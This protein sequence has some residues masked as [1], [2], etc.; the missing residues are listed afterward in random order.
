[1]HAAER[2]GCRDAQRPLSLRRTPRSIGLGFFNSG[3]DTKDAIIEA[4]SGF[5]ERNLSCRAL[6]K[7]RAESFLEPLDALG[8]HRRGEAEGAARRRHAAG[9]NHARE[10]F[11]IPKIRHQSGHSFRER[12]AAPRLSDAQSRCST[13]NCCVSPI[14]RSR[15]IQGDMQACIPLSQSGQDAL[16]FKVI[17]DRF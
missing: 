10:D 2:C 17:N 4:L 12:L 8:D 11:Q 7:S 1:M 3:E 5:R 16:R 15:S 6:Q 13:L 14:L 9:R